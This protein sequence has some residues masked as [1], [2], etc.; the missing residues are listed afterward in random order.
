MTVPTYQRQD[1]NRRGRWKRSKFRCRQ[2]QAGPYQTVSYP[3]RGWD[4][5]PG[6]VIAIDWV[7]GR[8]G[9]IWQW[10]LAR[11]PRPARCTVRPQY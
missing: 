3:R 1:S 5:L 7:T 6:R 10:D 2:R 11:P 4:P 8:S 9:R